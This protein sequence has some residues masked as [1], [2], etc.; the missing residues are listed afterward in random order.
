[1]QLSTCEVHGQVSG[2]AQQKAIQDVLR[3][4]KPDVIYVP[5]QI[6]SEPALLSILSVA[7]EDCCRP[8][9]ASSADASVYRWPAASEAGHDK[10]LEHATNRVVQILPSRL[11]S[12][13]KAL[14]CM[15][16]VVTSDGIVARRTARESLEQLKSHIGTDCHHAVCAAGGLVA[17]L[18]REQ[19]LLENDGKVF[20]RHLQRLRVQKLVQI[21]KAALRSL[22]IINLERHPSL[23]G[24]GMCKEGYSVFSMLDRCVTAKG[25]KLLQDWIEAP[26]ADITELRRRQDAI[27]SLL[28]DDSSRVH[29]RS[30]MSQVGEPLQLIQKLTTRAAGPQMPDLRKLLKG[31]EASWHLATALLQEELA[32]SLEGIVSFVHAWFDFKN[33]NQ[34]GILLPGNAELDKLKEHY[35][36]LPALLRSVADEEIAKVPTWLA[37]IHCPNLCLSCHFSGNSGYLVF[38]HGSEIPEA[39]LQNV[40]SDYTVWSHESDFDG[41][42][43]VFYRCS[44]TDVLNQRVGDIEEKVL[45]Y[46]AQ[47]A[48]VALLEIQDELRDALTP[49]QRWLAEL[50]VTCAM[51]EV[52]NEKCFVRPVLTSSNTLNIVKGWH[53]LVAALVDSFHPNDL[54]MTEA[55]SRILIVTGANGSGKSIF[56]QQVGIIVYLAHIGCFVPAESAEI[57]LTDAIFARTC[58]DGERMETFAQ[59]LTHL[60]TIMRYASERSL[61][62]MDELGKGTLPVDGASLLMSCLSHLSLQAKP[63]KVICVTH[64]SETTDQDLLPRNDQMQFGAMAMHITQVHGNTKPPPVFLY[65][66]LCPSEVSLSSFA[67][68]CMAQS[69]VGEDVIRRIE[70][71][72]TSVGEGAA[73]LPK[74]MPDS[75]YGR[76]AHTIMAAQE[77]FLSG[78][79]HVGLSTKV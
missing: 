25:K 56:L 74:A 39:L 77:M 21:S 20:V 60:G 68:H 15:A 58:Q 41:C 76:T 57:G 36:G 27:Q 64:C 30:L 53:P 5:A 43:G 34:I 18:I 28:H 72:Q 54:R 55:L 66:L 42:E 78:K 29:L 12:F 38:S 7:G 9:V 13:A 63:P 1:M 14:A 71:I 11:F 50:D 31:L 62:L 48:R 23:M 46:E 8:G 47:L 69:G 19:I 49:N 32:I 26:I 51:A 52:C 24:I 40:F 37:S 73:F 65:R 2:G 3:L 17:T 70:K 22:R 16:K 44:A 61:V 35:S 79:N 33:Q 45:T 4:T 75:T 59:D 6:A 67:C 10:V